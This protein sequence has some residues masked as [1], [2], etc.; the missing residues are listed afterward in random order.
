M[1]YINQ[2][3]IVR[4]VKAVEDK[5]GFVRDYNLVFRHLVEEVGELSRA[6]WEWEKKG[7]TLDNPPTDGIGR[8]IVDV[9]FIALWL[10]DIVGVDVDGSIPRAMDE[11]SAQYGVKRDG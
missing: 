6:I 11:I 8:E 2:T 5:K 3:E 9:V 10:A 7:R 4:F 1:K